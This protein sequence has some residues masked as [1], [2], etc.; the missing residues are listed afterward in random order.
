MIIP[1][2]LDHVDQVAKLHCA[3]LTGLLTKLGE[4]AARAFYI[5]CV[6]TGT[7]VGFVDL[8]EGKVRGFVMGSVHPD[9]LKRAIVKKNPVGMLAGLFLGV[10]RRPVAAVLLLKS[11]KGPD[12]GGYDLQAPEL[13]YLAVSSS[14]RGGGIG[15][16]LVDR[17]TQ[18]MR[19]VNISAYELSVDDSNERAIVFYERRGFKQVC[20]Y[21]EFGLLRRRYRFQ[22]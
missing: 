13:I 18:A 21:R 6:K 17:F 2:G 9:T 11:F 14:F 7:A 19:E 1:L 3:T 15:E 16:G 4:T 8:Q 20:L 10:L 22:C 5:G 12:E